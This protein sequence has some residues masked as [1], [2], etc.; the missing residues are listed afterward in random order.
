MV[1]YNS[2]T[3]AT[4]FYINPYWNPA[5]G[6]ENHYPAK[7]PNSWVYEWQELTESYTYT[8]SSPSGKTF[9]VT[10][11]PPA[12]D[13]YFNGWFAYCS[14]VNYDS[15]NAYQFITGYDSATKTFTCKT[16][17]DSSWIATS[18]VKLIRFPVVLFHSGVIPNPNVDYRGMDT[19][20]KALPTQFFASLNEVRITC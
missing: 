5:E 7:T 19:T 1:Y 15:L 16:T 17:L 20:F 9:Q 3:K 4:K 2:T 6:Y 12:I 8:V 13:G 14:N 10:E 18:A 11:T